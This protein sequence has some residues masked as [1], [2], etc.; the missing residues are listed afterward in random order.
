VG[1]QLPF[2]GLFKSDSVLLRSPNWRRIALRGKPALTG[3]SQAILSKATSAS[4]E[5]AGEVLLP[6][7]FLLMNGTELH[8]HWTG[9]FISQV[10]NYSVTFSGGSTVTVPGPT[11]GAGLPRTAFGLI[12]LGWIF[13]RH[14]N[15]NKN[16]QSLA[17]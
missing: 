15:K 16:K 7:V 9:G 1:Q 13:T 2:I 3:Q 10:E 6:G 4:R 17:F 11:I 12:G 5:S 14:K 8:L